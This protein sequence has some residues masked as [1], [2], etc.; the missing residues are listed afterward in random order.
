MKIGHVDVPDQGSGLSQAGNTST[1]KL[2][3]VLVV[4]NANRPGVT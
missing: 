1:A 4:F 3:A 2:S